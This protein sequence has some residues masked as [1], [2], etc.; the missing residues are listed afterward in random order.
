MSWVV[1]I[2]GVRF[3]GER[4]DHALWKSGLSHGRAC[5]KCGE[6]FNDSDLVSVISCGFD[7]FL[8]GAFHRGECQA[9]AENA[10]DQAAKD[11]VGESILCEIKSVSTRTG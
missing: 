2:W 10:I 5:Y 11:I 9:L 4:L 3:P 1:E 8:S 7:C 6:L